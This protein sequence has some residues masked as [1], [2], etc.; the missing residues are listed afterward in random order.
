MLS[1]FV[2]KM[3][4]PTK[5]QAARRRYGHEPLKVLDVGCGNRSCE[6][7]KHWLNINEYVG[8]DREYWNGDKEGYE[9]INRMVFA[10]LEVDPSLCEVEEGVFDL[11]ILH[12][13]IEHLSNGEAVLAGLFT[14]LR[15]GGMIYLETP[16]ISTL[17]YPTAIGFL[18]FYDDKT[19][20]RIYETRAL[21][22]EM[23]RIGFVVNRYGRRRDWRR[24]ALFAIPMLIYNMLYSLPFLRRLDARGLWDFFGVASF[25][26]ATKQKL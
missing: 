4:C 12:H 22:S 26:I 6:I 7:A 19:H 20:R 9:G 14:K 5:L 11:V 24:I 17:N 1:I 10:D 15:P 8:V 2:K 3:L 23:M 18:N 16:D 13:V 25:V 21:V